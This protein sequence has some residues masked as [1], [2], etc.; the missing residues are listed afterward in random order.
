MLEGRGAQTKVEGGVVRE[1]NAMRDDTLLKSWPRDGTEGK[2]EAVEE[3]RTR[4]K[5]KKLRVERGK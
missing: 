3:M 2:A 5:K 4:T 1:Y